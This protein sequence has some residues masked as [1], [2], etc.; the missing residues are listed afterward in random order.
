MTSAFGFGRVAMSLAFGA[1]AARLDLGYK[2]VNLR[3]LPWFLLVFANFYGMLRSPS[4]RAG[5][6]LRT[7]VLWVIAD[8][9]FRFLS[10]AA[11]MPAPA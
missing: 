9:L 6:F 4:P 3:R 7:L 1:L 2:R 5:G 11:V 10:E 8:L